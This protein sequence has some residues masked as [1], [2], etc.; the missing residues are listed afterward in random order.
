M[1][2]KNPE[3]PFHPWKH[4]HCFGQDQ[5]KPGEARTL[6][7]IALTAGMMVIEIAA[8]WAYGSMAL[9]ADGLHMASHAAALS[10][11]AF[12]YYFARK[13]AHDRSFTFGTG[14]VNSLGGFTGAVL[15]VLFGLF[16]VTESLHRLVDPVPIS[17]NQAIAVAIVGLI[18]NGVSVFV[19]G[20]HG[21]DHDLNLRAAYL[22]VLADTLTSLLA[23]FALLVAKYYGWVWMD[24][25]MG[26]VGA[27]LITKWSIG[28]LRQS[29][30][31][32]LDQQ[33]PSHLVK[34]IT[35][36]LT[37]SPCGSQVVDLHVWSIGPNIF[38]TAIVVLSDQPQVLVPI[39]EALKDIPEI[40]HSTVEVHPTLQRD[41]EPVETP[42]NDFH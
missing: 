10:I 8:G 15:L 39:K 3:H 32:L 11:S 30:S 19:L 33:G 18:V 17:F 6:V 27:V 28:L 23:I 21:H 5:K 22:H 40:V 20:H 12:A 42:G 7:V 29:G 36:R 14:K 9:L 37:E 16:M 13:R 26:V 34:K 25:I 2:I 35:N 4:D 24:P 38:S 1:K 31:V 41:S